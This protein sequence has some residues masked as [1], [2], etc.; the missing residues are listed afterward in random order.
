MPTAVI[1]GIETRYDVIGSGPPILMY[2]PGGF[3]AVIETWVTQGVYAKIRLLD[4]L[5][6]GF[7]CVTFD[8]RECGQSGGR[9]EPITWAHYVAQGKGLLDHLGIAR[10][11]IMGGCMGCSPVTAFAVAHPDMVSTMILYWPVGGARYRMSSHRRFAEHLDFVQ[12][13]GLDG[14]VALVSKEGKH[15]GADPR[16]GPWAVVI[17]RD[18]GFAAT[19]AAQNADRYTL[20]CEAMCG[21]L[22]DRDTAPG[23]E[24]EDL[25]RLDIP[26][27][28]V[29]GH[30]AAH[31]TSAARYLEECLP[32]SEYWDVAVESQSEGATNTRLSEFLEKTSR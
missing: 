23:A 24:P 31:A 25:M 22:F 9:V 21:A 18:R 30:D 2:A 5:P 11:H 13:H 27:F 29:P 8:R 28:I 12:S 17:N 10:A 1:D 15:F 26:A 20:T 16:G 7:T 6:K 19:Y 4:H 3:N 14:V 32:R